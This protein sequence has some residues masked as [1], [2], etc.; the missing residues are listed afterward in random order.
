[1]M[2]D[3]LTATTSAISPFDTIKHSDE[4]GEHWSARELAMLLGYKPNAWHN[5]EGVIRQAMAACQ[6]SGQ[7][8]ERHFLRVETQSPK[9]KR[10]YPI[11][12][13]HL[14]RYACY[15][16]VENA[17]PSKEVVALGQTYFAIRTRQDEETSARE[18]AEKRVNER[19]KL[20]RYHKVLFRTARLVGVITPQDF[21]IFEDHGYR[22]L[23]LET[24]QQI[25]E[26]KGLDPKKQNIS[27]Y[28]GITEMAANGFR[29]ALANEMLI[30]EH[31][32]S[33]EE[34]YATHYRAGSI[35]RKA[36]IEANVPPP[37]HLPTPPQSIQQVKRE[38][39]RQRRIEY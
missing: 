15:L 7:P 31:T 34:A 20:K 10:R 22:G 35:V 28:M 6:N 2:S 29:A 38:S 39:A 32:Q 13:Y 14:S 37:E 27:D 21:A 25:A 8:I 3:G 18:T 16:L 4:Q 12:D 19:E 17:D 23:Y 26:R 30:G 5:F 36:M 33:K 9:A 11:S 24:A 1:M